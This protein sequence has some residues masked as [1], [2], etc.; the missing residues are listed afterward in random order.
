MGCSGI[1]WGV[2]EAASVAELGDPL[3]GGSP[4]HSPPG[5][6]GGVSPLDL[7]L[8]QSGTHSMFP[9]AQHNPSPGDFIS[10]SSTSSSFS[11]FSP[12]QSILTHGWGVQLRALPR[13]HHPVSCCD[14]P[15]TPR[16]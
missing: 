4:Q 6:G 14:P 9:Q 5:R 13:W 1:I 15:G 7:L 11:S 3:G 16:G 12:H 8:S 10:S 2:G